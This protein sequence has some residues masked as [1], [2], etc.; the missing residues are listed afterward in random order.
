MSSIRPCEAVGS[1]DRLPRCRKE[2]KINLAEGFYIAQALGEK[3]NTAVLYNLAPVFRLLERRERDQ[4][5]T[6]C[7]PLAPYLV[8]P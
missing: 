6:P 7:R 1:Q 5:C 8:T 3:K 2:P 4:A